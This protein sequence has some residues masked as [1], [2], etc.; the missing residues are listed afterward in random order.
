M[1]RIVLGALAAALVAT[2]APATAAPT[3][4]QVSRTLLVAGVAGTS[5]DVIVPKG[6]VLVGPRSVAGLVPGFAI[7]GGDSDHWWAVALISRSKKVAGKPVNAIQVHT[8]APDHCPSQTAPSVRPVGECAKLVEHTSF[9]G[10][11]QTTSGGFVRYALPAGTYQVALAGP[12]G[13]LVVAALH[14]TAVK[15]PFSVLL[16]KKAFAAGFDR[17]RGSDIAAAQAS[18]TFTRKL[19]G[20]G[21]AVLGVWHTVAE[22]EPGPFAYAQ[23]VAAASLP[24]EPCAA[25]AATGQQPPAAVPKPVYGVVG[26][27]VTQVP[28]G[29]V[30]GQTA[31]LR[32]GTYTHTVRVARAGRG[33]AAGAFVFWLQTDALK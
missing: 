2:V 13:K 32:A 11:P 1:R 27:P 16:T 20:N 22:P 7:S 33:P 15:T 30:T 31:L 3:V 19:T 29:Q 12:P 10:V 8:P 18:G 23:C 6:A 28:T 21:L 25:V 17:V 4:P 9:H 14:F 5:V 26:G 24:A